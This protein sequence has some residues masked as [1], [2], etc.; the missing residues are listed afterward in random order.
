M[1]RPV[2]A[3]A[4]SLNRLAKYASELEEVGIVRVR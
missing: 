2:T 3:E 4:D 1:Q